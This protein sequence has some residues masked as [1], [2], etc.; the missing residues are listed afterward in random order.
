MFSYVLR[1]T[2]LHYNSNVYE[3]VTF[4]EMCTYVMVVFATGPGSE[5]TITGSARLRKQFL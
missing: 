3:S 4:Q 1:Y 2:I 5:K